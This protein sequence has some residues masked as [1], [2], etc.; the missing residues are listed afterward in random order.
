MEVL[1]GAAALVAAALLVWAVARLTLR[2]FLRRRWPE[3][4]GDGS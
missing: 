2:P 3:D 1:I 4:A